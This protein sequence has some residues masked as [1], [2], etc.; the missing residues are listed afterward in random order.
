M[1]CWP[2]GALGAGEG[3]KGSQEGSMFDVGRVRWEGRAQMT[4]AG[5]P[6][7]FPEVRRV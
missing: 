7:L 4:D 3:E 1:G 2:P 5:V 6:L